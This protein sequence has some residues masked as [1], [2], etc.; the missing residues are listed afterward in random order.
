MA[1]VRKTI[2]NMEKSLAEIRGMAEDCFIKVPR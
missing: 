1:T 2:M